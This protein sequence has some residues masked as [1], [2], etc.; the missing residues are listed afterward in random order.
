M[1]YVFNIL[2][3]FVVIWIVWSVIDHAP[4]KAQTEISER[5]VEKDFDGARLHKSCNS[6]LDRPFAVEFCNDEMFVANTIAGKDGNDSTGF[7]CRTS[8]SGE[9]VDNLHIDG[10]KSPRGMTVCDGYLY[11]TDLNCIYKYD[12][13]GDSIEA[14][15]PIEGAKRLTDIE[16]DRT[17]L[18][19]VSDI[20][21][22]KIY[23]IKNDTA[24][25]FVSDTLL[26]GVSGLAYHA[27]Y[28]FAGA[29]KR[30][31]RVD[32]STGK[33]R[34]FAHVVYPVLGFCSDDNGNFITTDFVGNVYVVSSS[35]Q[36][37]LIK[38]RQGINA[39]GIGYIPEQK[40]LAVP[41]YANNSVDVYEIG[42]YLQQNK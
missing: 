25:L 31:V 13:D 22:A 19:Y 17:G 21:D 15:I 23:R 27:G 3:A 34:I 1:K 28:I 41:T 30:I 39:A 24:S 38:K 42:R 9:F 35:K 8:L 40:L 33:V 5:S 2:I 16:K 36:Q 32:V 11:I 6:H 29:N 4:K 10:L 26:N 12:I 37:L 18:L 20:Q 14:I 7:V